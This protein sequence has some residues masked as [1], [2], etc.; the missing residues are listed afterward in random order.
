M[1]QNGTLTQEPG[2]QEPPRPQTARDRAAQGDYR[3]AAEPI[4]R[5]PGDAREHSFNPRARLADGVSGV[6]EEVRHNGLGLREEFWVHFYAAR[7]E[8]LM[9]A[10]A[11]VDSLL[12]HIEQGTQKEQERE[13][14]RE[15]RGDVKVDF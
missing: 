1:E 3:P 7:R 14:R 9:A 4:N 15:R 6:V 5:K 11:F 13:K 2:T 12:G 8:G 10:R